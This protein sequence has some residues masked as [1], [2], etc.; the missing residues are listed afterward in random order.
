[1]GLREVGSYAVTVGRMSR[2]KGTYEAVEHLAGSGLGLVVIGGAKESENAA[3]RDYGDSLG[4]TVRVL[5][6]IDSESMRAVMRNSS[7]IIGL[8]HG[9]AFGLTPIEAMALGAP[10]VFVN[11]GGYTE[12][13]VDQFNGRLVER[14]DIEAWHRALEQASDPGTRDRWARNGLARIEE[15]GLTPQ[16]HAERLY[17]IIN[18]DE[19]K[20]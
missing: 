12:T 18:S 15:L 1:M 2:F 10:P 7:A 5:S 13:I 8:A 3:L 19:H 16:D 17:S 11:E 9:E 4:V 14:G 6:G 20:Q